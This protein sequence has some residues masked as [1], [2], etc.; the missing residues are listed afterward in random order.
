L[1]QV[2]LSVGLFELHE[3][4]L[5]DTQITINKN[6]DIIHVY[7]RISKTWKENFVRDSRYAE[8]DSFSTFS[9]M[10]KTFMVALCGDLWYEEILKEAKKIKSAMEE[11]WEMTRIFKEVAGI[12]YNDKRN[13][14]ADPIYSSFLNLFNII[15][16]SV[17]TEYDLSKAVFC[18]PIRPGSTVCLVSEDDK[19]IYY[20]VFYCETDPGSK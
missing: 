1:T 15:R 18:G 19:V 11:L 4:K 13:K 5:Y 3:G 7:R 17:T 20:A 6:G 8:G 10:D 16:D 12:K 14:F 2:A 9:L